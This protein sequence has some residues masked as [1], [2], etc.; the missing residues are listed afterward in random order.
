MN[1]VFPSPSGPPWHAGEREAQRRAGVAERMERIGGRRIRPFMPDQ[2]RQ[3][4]SQ[5]PFLI[6]GSV[7][8]S[9]LPW[10]SLL[11]G[12]P[13]FATTPDE[14]TL[15]VATHLPEGDPLHVALRPD[16]MLGILG[17]ELATRRRNR[18]NGRVVA[19]DDFGF[20]VTVDQSFGNCPQYIQ[21][22]ETIAAVSSSR[23]EVEPFTALSTAA[24][25]LIQT[26]DTFF[27]ATFSRAEGPK[28]SLGVDVSHRGGRPGFVDVAADGT[29]TVP[30][31]AGN[32]F[33]NTLGNLIANP[34]AGL[35]FID[36]ETGDLL[37]FS[38]TTD[39][40]WEGSEIAQFAGAERLWRVRPAFG[41][42]LR[43]GFP[44][45]LTSPEV[46]PQVLTTGTWADARG[47]SPS[48]AP[49]RDGFRQ[50]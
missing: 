13:G 29:V 40:V 11:A 38:G 22:R 36:F 42:W 35:L 43:G 47:N 10:A 7:G 32:R 30:D 2:H 37:Q 3:F 14:R 48:D 20:S 27:V 31:F 44:F 33:F 9:G 25:T 12:Q 41:R 28:A 26:A 19:V 6:I 17:I 49:Q 45:R 8:V 1:E 24:R 39:V 15:Q 4:F 34:L 21:R 50:P 23:G 46:S 5:L 16:A 18:I